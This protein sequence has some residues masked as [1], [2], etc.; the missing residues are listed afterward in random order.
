MEK[1]NGLRVVLFPLPIQGCINP[2][3]QLAK[4]LHSRGFSITVIHTRFNTPKA[5]NH[6]L[7]TFLEIQDGLSE[8]EAS[9]R[10]VTLVLTLL[11]QSCCRGWIRPSPKARRID[12]P[13]RIR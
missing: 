1:S 2:M 5:S 13:I 6:P 4:I 10:D 11:N 3:F 8:A 7:Y 9:T 12:G